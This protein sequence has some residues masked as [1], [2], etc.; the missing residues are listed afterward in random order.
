MAAV[1]N[2]CFGIKTVRI[3]GAQ[4]DYGLHVGRRIKNDYPNSIN[5]SAFVTVALSVFCGVR[6]NVKNIV[7]LSSTFRKIDQNT[8]FIPKSRP[9]GC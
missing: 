3:L 6:L 4:S 5:S 8:P 2:A 9:R 1:W 7:W